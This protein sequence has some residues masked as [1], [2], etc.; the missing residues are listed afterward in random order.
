MKFV[1]GVLL[2]HVVLGVVDLGHPGTKYV[3][4]SEAQVD[5]HKLY[6]NY[7]T[8]VVTKKLVKFENGMMNTAP[9]REGHYLAWGLTKDAWKDVG[10][11][12]VNAGWTMRFDFNIPADTNPNEWFYM[13]V[14]R[15]TNLGQWCDACWSW[16][17]NPTHCTGKLSNCKMVLPD[18]NYD[19]RS[20]LG[21]KETPY[22]W[23]VSRNKDNGFMNLQLH[24]R[25]LGASSKVVEMEVNKK[26]DFTNEIP[27]GFY[28]NSARANWERAGLVEY[29]GQAPGAG[30]P[31]A[32]P[33]TAVDANGNALKV[34][35]GDCVLILTSNLDA[36]SFSNTAGE[37]NGQTYGTAGS[38][39]YKAG[40]SP[41]DMKG[42][43]NVMMVT[44]DN[45]KSHV[46]AEKID[47]VNGFAGTATNCNANGN[48]I[49][50]SLWWAGGRGGCYSSSHFGVVNRDGGNIHNTC[51]RDGHWGHF[52][53]GGVNTGVYAFGDQCVSEN[54]WD[55]VFNYYI[56]GSVPNAA[57]AVCTDAEDC[58]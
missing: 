41:D 31:A 15:P 11:L 27:I 37:F 38:S 32:T 13:Q 45:G 54:E 14:D 7:Y 17:H 42:F 9:G 44:T 3:E 24:R 53:R 4:L 2:L 49:G 18:N 57:P 43:G 52:H 12:D 35:N 40:F 19:I 36:A 46:F 55:T 30:A 20:I 8:G 25:D 6:P 48:K 39:S 50:P 28:L 10:L 23:I 1:I 47:D 5:A 56:C 16:A 26:I 58:S 22:S 29:N 21:N 34:I 33:Q 51:G